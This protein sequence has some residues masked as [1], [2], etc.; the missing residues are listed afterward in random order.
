MTDLDKRIREY[1]DCLDS[2]FNEAADDRKEESWNYEYNDGRCD[3]YYAALQ[4]FRRIF[5]VKEE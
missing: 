5:N 2:A 4:D 1:M 3:A